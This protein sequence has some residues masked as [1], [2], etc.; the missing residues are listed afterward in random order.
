V[1]E[2]IKAETGLPDY[3][4]LYSTKEWK[5]IRVQYFVEDDLSLEEMVAP[6]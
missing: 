5:K 1:A 4:L 3:D 6:V 2:A